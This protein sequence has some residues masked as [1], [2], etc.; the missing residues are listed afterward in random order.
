[1]RVVLTVLLFTLA[2][3]VMNRLLII[4]VKKIVRF[5][6]LV[7]RVAS[8]MAI[9]SLI[10][11]ANAALYAE[12]DILSFR[13]NVMTTTPTMEMVA[14]SSVRWNIYM[15]ASTNPQNVIYT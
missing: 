10:L 9:I 12:T 6:G 8:A 4:S 5:V 7:M 13:N 3:N 2:M 1:M 14:H 11:L 15:L